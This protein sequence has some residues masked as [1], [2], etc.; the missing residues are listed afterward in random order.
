MNASSQAF[1]RPELSQLLLAQLTGG[2]SAQQHHRLEALLESNAAARAVYLDYMHDAAVMRQVL[3]ADEADDSDVDLPD[4]WSIWSAAYDM[5]IQPMALSVLVSGLVITTVVLS[6][7]LITAP[8]WRTAGNGEP[9]YE[10]VASIKRTSGARWSAASDVAPNR[11]TDLLAGDSVEL[12][13]GHAELH[14]RDG[15][16]VLLEAPARF[17]PQTSNSGELLRGKLT[18]QVPAEAVGFTINTSRVRV[19]DLGTEFGVAAEESGDTDV[20]VVSGE[21]ELHPQGD[22]AAGGEDRPMRVA[23]GQSVRI[24]AAGVRRVDGAAARQFTRRL[25][26]RAAVQRV[27][28]GPPA[29]IRFVGEQLNLTAFR[30]PAVPKQ[31]DADG[32]NIYGTAGYYF[33]NMG[34]Q[35]ERRNE[36]FDRRARG[37]LPS[38][39]TAIRPLN[40]TA[41][42]GGFGYLQIDDP[43][44][45]TAEVVADIES[46]VAALPIGD[47]SL[48]R[49]QA[50]IAIVVGEPL[51]RQGF[52]LGVFTDNINQRNMPAAIRITGGGGDSGLVTVNHDAN[53][54]G[55]WFFFDVTAAQPGDVLRI[56]INNRGTERANKTLGGLVFDV[57]PQVGGR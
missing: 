2:L 7:A 54:Q 53:Q 45:N 18:A 30:T 51:P 11:V 22:G 19:V 25:P 50:M 38:F 17:T 20:T 15:A 6:L 44:A 35:P 12:L 3:L 24:D 1:D 48:E 16:I 57:P 34:A 49:E 43:R 9:S 21:V 56:S 29:E 4:R 36:S 37:E 46:G 47:V 40:A 27:R 41:S 33:L 42:A 5:L 23:A 10:F 26:G 8:E 32:D 13:A 14:F 31:Y 39:I 28:S 55:D 52:R